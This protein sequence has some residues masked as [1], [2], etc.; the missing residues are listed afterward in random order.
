MQRS[1]RQKAYREQMAKIYHVFIMSAMLLN[2]FRRRLQMLSACHAI[3]GTVRF[4]PPESQPTY[5]DL[6]TFFYEIKA[7]DL[8]PFGIKAEDFYARKI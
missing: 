6:P 5:A 1:S 8:P 3:L 4:V 7:E 2:V